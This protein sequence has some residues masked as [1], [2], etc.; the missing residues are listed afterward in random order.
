MLLAGTLYLTSLVEMSNTNRLESLGLDDII[1]KIKLACDSLTFV[2]LQSYLW[3][4]VT[5]DTHRYDI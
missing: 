4:A 2:K 5:P 1:L 3:V